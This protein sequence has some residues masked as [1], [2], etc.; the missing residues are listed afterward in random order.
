MRNIKRFVA[1]LVSE[2]TEGT[3]WHPAQVR[4]KGFCLTSKE[5][6]RRKYLIV[7]WQEHACPLSTSVAWWPLKNCDEYWVKEVA[8]KKNWAKP[9]TIYFGV[10]H[11]LLCASYGLIPLPISIYLP[12]N[13]FVTLTYPGSHSTSCL[14]WLLHGSRQTKPPKTGESIHV[15]NASYLLC[16]VCERRNSYSEVIDCLLL[17]L[18]LWSQCPLKKILK[19][20]KTILKVEFCG[21]LYGTW[22]D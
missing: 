10:E 13:F 16:K 20:S 2:I 5:L 22:S 4:N 9:E 18:V 8:F 11:I 12:S 17:V 7:S 6:C 1:V 19:S 15:G 21:S 3:G 14:S